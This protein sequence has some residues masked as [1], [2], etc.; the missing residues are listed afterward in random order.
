M[1]ASGLHGR[2]RQ[3]AGSVADTRDQRYAGGQTGQCLIPI[4]EQLDGADPA[5]VGRGQ[6]GQRPEPIHTGDRII[7][8][9]D[10]VLG[11]RLLRWP[12]R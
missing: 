5:C 6:N 10:D 8:A 7:A 3:L 12:R 9:A 11:D 4:R 2:A 1:T